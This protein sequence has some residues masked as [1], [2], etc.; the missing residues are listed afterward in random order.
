VKKT[1]E[2]GTFLLEKIPSFSTSNVP[3]NALLKWAVG[4]SLINIRVPTIDKDP[5]LNPLQAL[6]KASNLY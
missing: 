1:S 3:Y 2:K 6:V 5:N 4:Y